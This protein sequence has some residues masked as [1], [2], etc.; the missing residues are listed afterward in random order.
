MK[1]KL[2][3]LL[4]VFSV[5]STQAQNFSVKG[6]VTDA[7]QEAIIAA[8]VSLWAT[9]STLVTGCNK[10]ILNRHFSVKLNRHMI[11]ETLRL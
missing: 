8:N 1:T 3:L 5:L 11:F 2:F 7:S 9:D 10:Q 6:R 4:L